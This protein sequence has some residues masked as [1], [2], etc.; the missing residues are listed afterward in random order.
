MTYSHLWNKFFSGATKN[1]RYATLLAIE[2]VLATGEKLPFTYDALTEEPMML[3]EASLPYAYGARRCE[4]E[5]IERL[6][7]HARA[8]LIQGV[9]YMMS[10]PN[11]M[12][13][14]L[15]TQL[16]LRIGNHIQ[17]RKSG[18]SGAPDLIVEIVSATNSSHDYTVK[19]IRAVSGFYGNVFLK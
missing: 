13:Q 11:R 14:F 5:D 4:G 18:C 6:S 17:K 7:E 1:P 15:V 3:R 10:A 9:L 2:Q 8:E 19:L 16:I 12:H